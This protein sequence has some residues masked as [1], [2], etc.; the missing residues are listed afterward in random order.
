MSL[1][2]IGVCDWELLLWG[3]DTDDFIGF[4]DCLFVIINLL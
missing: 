2:I 1:G 3:V 4:D